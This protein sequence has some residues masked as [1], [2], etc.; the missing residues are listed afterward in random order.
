MCSVKLYFS[1]DAFLTHNIPDAPEGFITT[2]SYAPTVSNMYQPEVCL[3][4]NKPTYVRNGCPKKHNLCTLE[5]HLYISKEVHKKYELS[6]RESRSGIGLSVYQIMVGFCQ[7]VFSLSRF[8]VGSSAK[9]FLGC[10]SGRGQSLYADDSTSSHFLLR[11]KEL[12]STVTLFTLASSAASAMRWLST[13]MEASVFP[14]FPSPIIFTKSRIILM[15]LPLCPF[16][17]V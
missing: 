1:L 6:L 10:Q 12:K 17:E 4:L 7:P 11:K 9:G 16:V 15:S 3:W 14:G 2:A 5:K 8:P 13:D